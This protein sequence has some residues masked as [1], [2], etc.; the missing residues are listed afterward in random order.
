MDETPYTAG[1]LSLVDNEGERDLDEALQDD[2]EDDVEFPDFELPVGVS[3]QK[4]G[5]ATRMVSGALP[6]VVFQ[7]LEQRYEA[8]VGGELGGE[9]D[10][11]VEP[12]KKKRKSPTGETKPSTVKKKATAKPKENVHWDYENNKLLNGDVDPGIPW[13]PILQIQFSML[14]YF[15]KQSNSSPNSN[16]YF[17]TSTTEA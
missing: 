12:K 2:S 9:S 1:I 8:A 16:G 15:E 3:E 6:S 11:E 10:T 4:V 13:R 17:H 7:F 14:V 5:G